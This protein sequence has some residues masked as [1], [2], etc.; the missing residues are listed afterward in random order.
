MARKDKIARSVANAITKSDVD[1][2]SLFRRVKQAFNACFTLYSIRLQQYSVSLFSDL[3]ESFELD[4]ETY[5][6]SFVQD[7]ASVALQAEGDMGF[8]GS[9]FFTTH[10]QKYLVKSVPRHFE[11]TFFR[12]DLLQPYVDYM[13]ANPHTLLIRIT[14]FLAVEDPYK[15][16][17][18]VLLGFAPSHH[19]IMENLLTGRQQGESYAKKQ[20]HSIDK[21][22]EW[23]PWDLKPTSYFFPERDIA[24]G[25]LTSKET[26]DKLADEFNDKI[27]LTA[28]DAKQFKQQMEKDTEL[29]SISNAVDYSLFLVRIPVPPEDEENPFSDDH[30][31]Q[32]A[33]TVP[34][35]KEPPFTPPGPPSWRTGIRS[36][37]GKYVYRAAVLDFFWAKHKLHA[38]MLTFLIN[39]WNKIDPSGDHGPMS[40]TT[41]SSEYRERFLKMCDSYVEVYGERE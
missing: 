27:R 18:G 30:E 7:D 28:E 16:S 39:T 1:D 8:S 40:V 29:L 25:K 20:P 13:M 38:K 21:A 34:T 24:K 14:D 19:I 35:P 6:S 23:Q 2:L 31:H 17:P 41:T 32:P 5:T 3:R 37:D 15:I 10:D 12:D 11:N 4:P 33:K 36:A 26:K 9:T 22:W